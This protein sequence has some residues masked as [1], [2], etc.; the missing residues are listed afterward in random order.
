MFYCEMTL[1]FAPGSARRSDGHGFLQIL[2]VIPGNVARQRLSET[3]DDRAG[4]EKAHDDIKK[5]IRADL[6]V[7]S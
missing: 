2:T 4:R 1:R 3:N 5:A 7:A 6:G